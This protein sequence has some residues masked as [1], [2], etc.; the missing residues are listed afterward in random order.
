MPSFADTVAQ[1][2]AAGVP[3]LFLDTCSVLDI[4]RAPIPERKLVG[5]VEAATEL[6]AQATAAPPLCSIIV[7]SFVPA[8]WGKNTQPVLAELERR[9]KR[10]DEEAELFHKLC[11][12]LA[13][14]HREC[15]RDP[16]ARPFK[17]TSPIGH[18]ARSTPRHER[19]SLHPGGDHAATPVSERWRTEGLHD[20]RGM[21]G[22]LSP[23]SGGFV[24]AEADLL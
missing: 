5:C 8:E 22:S 4:I 10:M 3:V 15:P 1:V 6:I 2:A 7:G 11:G 13:R 20:L 21:F 9:L 14:L 18:R 17:P 24:R 23:A 12:H 16:I 19:A